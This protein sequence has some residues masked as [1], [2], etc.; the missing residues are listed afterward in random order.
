MRRSDVK[1]RNRPWA[2]ARSLQIHYYIYYLL[3]IH[4]KLQ[5]EG[6]AKNISPNTFFPWEKIE[7]LIGQEHIDHTLWNVYYLFRYSWCQIDWRSVVTIPIWFDSIEH[8]NWFLCVHNNFF[9][10]FGFSLSTHSGSEVW[11]ESGM[12]P[13]RW[14][15]FLSREITLHICIYYIFHDILNFRVND[16]DCL[17]LQA[18]QSTPVPVIMA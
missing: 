2:P 6:K 3:I 1:C 8:I 15:E 10:F 13:I 5:I 16:L 4:T 12:K 7:L 14:F 9:F 18:G 11:E 17:A